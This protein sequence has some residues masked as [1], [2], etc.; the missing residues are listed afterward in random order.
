[1]TITS[2]QSGH[3]VFTSLV[4]QMEI[5]NKQPKNKVER[6]AAILAMMGKSSERQIAMMFG[7]SRSL[8]H[9]LH[10]RAKRKQ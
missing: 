3:D 2:N 1:M 7:V 8:V 10:S 9:F 5:A 6:D 4:N